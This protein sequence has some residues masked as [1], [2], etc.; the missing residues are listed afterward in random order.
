MTIYYVSASNGNNSN[1]GSQTS[2]FLTIQYASSFAQAGDTIIVEPGIYRERVAPTNSGTATGPITYISSVK[3][4]AIIRGSIPWQPTTNIINNI[5]CGSLIDSSFTDTSAL[6]GANPFKVPVS[7]SPYGRNG[8]PEAN[9]KMLNSDTNVIYSIGQ[10]FLDGI[11]LLQCPYFSEMQNT[12]NSWFYN[13]NTNQLYVNLPDNNPTSHLIEIS[14]QRRVF[15]P[16]QRGLK[17]IVV[18]GFTIEHCGNNYPNQFWT[19]PQNQHA[20]MIGTR[21][22]KY[23]TIQNNI[24]RFANGIGIDWG[25]EGGQSQ[26]LEIGANGPATGAYGHIIKNNVISDNGASGTASYMCK[27][28]TFSNNIIQRNNNLLFTG[29]HRWESAGVKVHQPTNSIIQNNIIEN[30]YCHGIWSDQGAGSNSIFQNNIIRYNSGSGINY[31]IGINT[32]GNVLKNIFYMNNYGVSFV[33]SGGV[34]IS[35]NLF[36]GSTIAD[37]YTN[38]FTRTADKW[39]SNNINIQNNMFLS[40]NNTY[41]QLSK[42]DPSVPSSRI[43]NNNIYSVDGK[44]TILA[45]INSKPSPISYNLDGWKTACESDTNSQV[46]P[47]TFLY[48]TSNNILTLNI[49]NLPINSQLPISTIPNTDYFGNQFQLNTIGI[50]ANL[51]VGSNIYQL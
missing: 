10:V 1:I 18:D 41:L 47:N 11:L 2:P 7:V 9:M 31:E 50:F 49:K 19:I 16:H 25:N 27:N 22:G 12:K 5:W 48:D 30:N 29:Q 51:K 35:N 21:S 15:A 6:D 17:Y 44:F 23:W 8:L 4:K 34:I 37:I 13:I 32:T 33:T 14:N 43:L 46:I 26:D 39:D 28:F 45:P 40:Q 42:S 36:L 20:G 3:N 38:I 24:I